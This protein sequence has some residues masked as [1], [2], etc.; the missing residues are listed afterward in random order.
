MSS[1]SHPKTDESGD[2]EN[3]WESALQQ[4]G[5]SKA[6]AAK[7]VLVLGDSNCGKTN[8]VSQLFQASLHPQTGNG[9][10]STTVSTAIGTNDPLS[11]IET[12][13]TLNKHDL[14]LS[15]SYMDVRD[16]DNEE[17]IARLGIFQLASD[18]TTDRE[19]LKYV[20]DARSFGDSAVVIVLDWSKPWR[21]VKSLLRWCNVLG[22]AI[23]CVC[24][25]T[26]GREAA[27]NKG[28]SGWTLGKATVDECRE[29]LE[30]FLQEYV[31][32]AEPSG[33]ALTGTQKLAAKAVDVL[34]PLAKGV[35]EENIGLPLI[36]VCTKADSMAVL[37]RERAFKEEDFDY[38]QQI[39]RAICLRFGAALIY[40]S[41]HNPTTFSTLYHYLVHRLLSTP[42]TLATVSADGE[43]TQLGESPADDETS[44]MD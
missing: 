31:E 20:L 5:S 10:D 23:E 27:S 32:P 24:K 2:T 37:E 11:E 44:R 9:Q 16:E 29:R 38:I 41:T 18:R 21:F 26:G 19:L 40:T 14:A 22:E 28:A 6:V 30:R 39:L 42:T 36:V 4:V 17:T 12:L 33:E 7:T 15:Y 13:V 25:D 34:L 1:N 35:L 8:V 43:E 3:L